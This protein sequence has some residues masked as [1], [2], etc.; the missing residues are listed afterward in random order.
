LAEQSFRSA[1][2]PAGD[3]LAEAAVAGV[4][5]GMLVGVGTGRTASRALAALAARV[6]DERLDVVCFGTSKVADALAA[7]MGLRV[8]S[9]SGRTT[10]DLLFDGADEVDGHLRM[11]KG[12][13]GAIARQRILA[14]AAR[15]A[16]YLINESKLV[17]R[18]G[19]RNTL[20]ICVFEFGLTW[21]REE[22]RRFGLS[23][24]VRRTLDGEV[25][26]SEHN[27]LVLDVSLGEQHKPEEVAAFLDRC[28]G[29]IEHGLFLS[30]AHE[31]LVES[32]D[33]RVKRL[34]RDQVT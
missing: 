21:I 33:G 29:V 6:R 16:V 12:Q 19:M 13:H 3:A 11:L 7:E 4:V 2:A 10:L 8:E 18:L 25:Y 31:V 14:H 5:S 32:S 34:V 17:Q 28:V 22:L 26:R 9:F 30:E 23:G 1:D 20:P 24:V 15:R 27:H